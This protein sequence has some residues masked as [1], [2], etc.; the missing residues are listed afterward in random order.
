MNKNKIVRVSWESHCTAVCCAAR[1]F[2]ENLCVHKAFENFFGDIA[3]DF[4]KNV[5]KFDFFTQ[6][7]AKKQTLSPTRKNLTFERFSPY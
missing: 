7:F 6:K 1:E 2:Y 4:F 5:V 3:T